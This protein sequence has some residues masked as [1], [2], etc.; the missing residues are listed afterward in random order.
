MKSILRVSDLNK[1]KILKGISFDIKEGEMTA[2]MGPSGSGKS[3]LLYNVSGMDKP[4]SGKVWLGN[5]ETEEQRRNRQCGRIGIRD[6]DP[7]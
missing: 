6:G 5:I 2:I 1:D 4:S 7:G 3:T